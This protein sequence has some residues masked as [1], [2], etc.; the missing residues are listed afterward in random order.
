MIGS[1]NDAQIDH[2]LLSQV[3]GRIGCHVSGKTYVVPVAYAFDG[4]YIYG[5]SRLGQKIQMMRKNS[6]VCFQV[7]QIDNLANWRCVVIDCEYEELTTV[8]QQNHAFALLKDRL[9][10]IITSTAA[11]PTQH[12]GEKKMRPVLF[13]FKILEKSGRFERQ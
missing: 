12:I 10:P 4:T 13:R 1:L 5:H 6:R 2:V 7:D 9:G 3:V 11:K 8:R